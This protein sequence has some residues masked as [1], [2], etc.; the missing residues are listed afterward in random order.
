MSVHCT[1]YNHLFGYA[2]LGEATGDCSGALT[3]PEL[4][5]KGIKIT[6]RRN[7]IKVDGFSAGSEQFKTEIFNQSGQLLFSTDNPV[8]RFE[9]DT[10]GLYL[11]KVSYKDKVRTEKVLFK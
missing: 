8:T 9:V 5:V 10:V 3:S 1:Q 2:L 7:V 11:V 4:I 6:N